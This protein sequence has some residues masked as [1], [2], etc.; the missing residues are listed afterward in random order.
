[1]LTASSLAL[2]TSVASWSP[3][4][5]ADIWKTQKE[6]FSCPLPKKTLLLQEA[7]NIKRRC[8]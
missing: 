4:N 1:M 5:I 6:E 3:D 2:V 8:S 7:C